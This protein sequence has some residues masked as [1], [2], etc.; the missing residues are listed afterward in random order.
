MPRK[1]PARVAKVE[2]QEKGWFLR[3]WRK[4]RGLNIDQLADLIGMHPAA[5][6]NLEN[7]QEK[8]RECSTRTLKLIA[9]AL[10]VPH[11]GLLT[12]MNP[13]DMPLW[14][15]FVT[16]DDIER[17]ILRNAVTGIVQTRHEATG[18]TTGLN[19]GASRLR[20]RAKD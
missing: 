9:Q 14:E 19:K 15:V 18:V 5:L 4:H 13:S 1:N 11:Y 3:E 6:S 10:D 16:A 20:N 8:D 2:P 7:A 12:M 17:G